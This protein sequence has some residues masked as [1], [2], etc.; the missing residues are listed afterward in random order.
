MIRNLQKLGTVQ[1]G[2]GATEIMN[3]DVKHGGTLGRMLIKGFNGSAACDETAMPSGI[4]NITLK[5]DM[6]SGDS[7]ALLNKVTPAFLTYRY[8]FFAGA[9]ALNPSMLYYDPAAGTRKDEGRRNQLTIGTADMS[10]LSMQ[11][12]FAAD[13]TGLTRL[14]VWG[15]VDF[16]LVQPLGEHIRIGSQSVGVPAAGGQVEIS[17]IPF[18]SASLCLQ[19]FHMQEP[20]TKLLV[21]DWTISINSKQFPYRDVPQDVIDQM[22]AFAERKKFAG[23]AT[24]D[25]NKEDVPAYF[26]QTGLGSLLVTPNFKA[27][28]GAVAANGRI[29]YEQIYKVKAV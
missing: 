28:D 24:I 23:F 6:Q 9:V 10:A 3:I 16:N 4:A 22:Q 15:E 13:T 17:T 21:N 26:F 7:F 19:A 11:F 1:V 29:W 12:E 8:V 27:L 18:D 2:D 20:S 25:F 14:E 5:A